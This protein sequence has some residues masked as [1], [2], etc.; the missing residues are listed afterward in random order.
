MD[1]AAAFTVR[2]EDAEIVTPAE[3]WHAKVYVNVAA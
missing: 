2:V 1:G 3:F